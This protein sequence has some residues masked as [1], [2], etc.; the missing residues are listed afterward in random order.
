MKQITTFIAAVIFTVSGFAGDTLTLNNAM[1]FGGKVIKIKQC[2]VVFTMENERYVIPTSDIFSIRFEDT[3]DLVYRN[4]L[5]LA[6]TDPNKCMNGMLDAE[7]YHGKKGSHF[8]LGMLFGPFAMIGTALADPT[9][10]RGARTYMMSKNKEQLTDLEYISCYR[11][12]ARS[13]LIGMEALGWGT[14]ILILLL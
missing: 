2:E 1:I 8:V 10:D 12:K 11:K 3:N 4:Y 13:Q 9:P 6:D 5:L 7:N 14:W